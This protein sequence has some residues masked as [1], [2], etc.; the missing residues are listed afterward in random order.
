MK[1]L[2]WLVLLGLACSESI[3]PMDSYWV[4]LGLVNRVRYFELVDCFGKRYPITELRTTRT[5][6]RIFGFYQVQCGARAYVTQKGDSLKVEWSGRQL[7]LRK[8]VLAIPKGGTNESHL[9]DERR[10]RLNGSRGVSDP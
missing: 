9:P 3:T 2:F 5:V 10:S 8:F 1:R 7:L 4:Y 6:I